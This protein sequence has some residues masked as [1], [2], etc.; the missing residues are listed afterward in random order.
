MSLRTIIN[1]DHCNE[2]IPFVKLQESVTMKIT[3]GVHTGRRGSFQ[4]SPFLYQTFCPLC[5]E[6]LQNTMHVPPLKYP[7]T[8]QSTTTP[9][10]RWEFER[11]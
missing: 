5:Y 8:M 1:C 4:N 2:E 10:Q 6:K 3:Q 11:L 7:P 9:V